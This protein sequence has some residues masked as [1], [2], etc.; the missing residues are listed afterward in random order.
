MNIKEIVF[1]VTET[2]TYEVTVSP[3]TGFSMPEFPKRLISYVNDI[4]SDPV[5]ELGLT[6]ESLIDKVVKVTDYDI[7]EGK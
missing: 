7:K 4:H 1:Y 3:E 6:D 2:K 5:G